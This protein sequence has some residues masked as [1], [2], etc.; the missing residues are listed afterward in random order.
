MSPAPLPPRFFQR[1]AVRVARELLG[2]L[3]VRRMPDG[4]LLTL[5][6]T[7]VEAYDGPNDR[8]C[9]AARGKTKRTWVMFEPGGCFYVY[10][11]YGIHWMLNIVCGD[12]DYPAAV[13][14]R[15][16]GR[17]SGPGRLTKY[18]QID[19]A[20]NHCIAEPASGLWIEPGNSVPED[21]VLRGPRI[22]IDYAGLEWAQK[23]WRF[24][25]QAPQTTSPEKLLGKPPEKSL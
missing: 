11:C 15:G 25:W 21:R 23:P 22:G 24:V 6:L 1:P 3:L 19:R 8:A 16:A 17:I 12:R 18:L 20:L 2:Q 4:S 5:P 7:E 10:L 13:L 9:H 14:V